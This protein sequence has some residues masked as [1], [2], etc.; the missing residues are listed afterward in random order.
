MFKV[1]DVL[2]LVLL[3]KAKIYKDLHY[4]CDSFL[5]MSN[6][7]DIIVDEI[8]EDTVICRKGV[9]HNLNPRWGLDFNIILAVNP[10]AVR[11]P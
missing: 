11:D 3:T 5:F 6:T 10:D 4:V 1:G 8:I 9:S 2:R 7:F